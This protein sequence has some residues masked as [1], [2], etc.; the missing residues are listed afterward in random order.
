MFAILSP[1]G[2]EFIL[3]WF[4]YMAGVVWIGMLY[5]FNF[6]QG[7]FMAEAEASWKSGV[8]QKLLPRGMWWFR[9]GAM[10]TF[11]T[12][13]G[14]LSQKAMEQHVPISSPWGTII[15]TGGILGTI[16]FLNVWLVI[17][18]NQ[19]IVIENATRVAKGEAAL[20]ETA[21]AAARAGIASRTNTLFS[22]P[23]LFFMGAASHL[24]ISMSPDKSMVPYWS[25]FGII[26][27]LIELNA[28]KGKMGPMAKIG[29]VIH[30]GL[31]LTV[32]YYFSIELLTK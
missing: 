1:A 29:G 16:M 14:L 7:P 4:H 32:V 9:W 12:G 31:L 6:V 13:W 18:P 3:R 25:V 20:P 27:A 23:L 5:Y 21:A 26:T 15:L 10:G 11:L 28:L 2:G 30:L 8:Q 19:K 17:W 22:I 24:P